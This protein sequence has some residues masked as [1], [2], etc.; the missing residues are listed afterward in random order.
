M[1]EDFPSKWR[2]KK[3][4]VAILVSDKIDFK[5][6]KIKRNKEGHYI[7]KKIDTRRANNPKHI[8]TLHRSTQIHKAS[9]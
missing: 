3:S 9:S 8:W 5:A 2:A 4:R 6:T 1:E 7:I